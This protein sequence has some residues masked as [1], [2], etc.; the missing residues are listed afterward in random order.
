VVSFALCAA[1]SLQHLR[2]LREV[3]TQGDWARHFTAIGRAL[4]RAFDPPTT[5]ALTAAGA[6]PYYSGLR[7]LDML[8]LTDPHIARAPFD[9]S[10]RYPG[11]QRHDGRYVLDRRPELILLANGPIA[12]APGAPFPWHKV[13][14]YERDVAEDPRL[15]ADYDLIQLPLPDGRAF[16]L[17]ARKDFISARR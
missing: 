3:R 13:R 4:D 11:H 12:T 15:K 9:D 17:F 10:Y 6:I 8:G 5:V 2:G 7:A 16:Q 14:I 1:L